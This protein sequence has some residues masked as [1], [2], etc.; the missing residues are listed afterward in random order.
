MKQ[1]ENE[2]AHCAEHNSDPQQPRF[3]QVACRI[4]LLRRLFPI[5]RSRVYRGQ[6]PTGFVKEQ[7]V[8][9]DEETESRQCH[10][11]SAAGVGE[12]GEKMCSVGSLEEKQV[13]MVVLG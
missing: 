13:W 1:E 5:R 9:V 3:G 11:E 10:G 8:K 4:G 6:K 12:L 2:A 7:E